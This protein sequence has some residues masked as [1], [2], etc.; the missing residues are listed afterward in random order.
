MIDCSATPLIKGSRH[1]FADLN[2]LYHPTGIFGDE[3][4]DLVYAGDVVNTTK[5]TPILLKEWFTL[6]QPSGYLTVDYRPNTFCD[7]QGLEETMWWLWKNKYEIVFHGPIAE[8][9]NDGADEKRLRGFIRGQEEIY[10]TNLNATT[11]LP[12]DAP[13]GIESGRRR[14]IC[15]KINSTRVVGDSIDKWS[16]GI[17]TSGTRKD[18]LDNIIA[19]IRRQKI[20]EYEIIVC[21]TYFDRKEADFKYIPF[22]Q[23]DEK[24]W[25]TK[26]KN[27]IGRAASFNNLCIMHDRMFLDDRWYEGMR[28]WGNSFEVLAVPQLFVET[29]ERFGDWVC[30]EGFSVKNANDF[31]PLRGGYLDYRDWHQD[32]P[33]YAAV[34]VAKKHIFASNS[35]NETLYWGNQ[36]EDLLLH[37][38]MHH[39]GYILRMN[40]DALTYSMTKSVIGF[41]W[42]HEF[43]SQEL[44]RLRKVNPLV[45][46]ACLVLGILGI[47]K[48]SRLLSPLKSFLKKRLSIQTHRSA[49]V[50]ALNTKTSDSGAAVNG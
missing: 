34:T 26:K 10:K 13:R 27:M 50:G 31:W 1:W 8:N 9:E 36:F 19:S 44:G 20:A 46:F 29:K 3:S 18:W 49:R 32:V 22:N 14:F 4:F 28:K 30:N 23:R 38:D 25:I 17:V 24:G 21:G 48:N 6:L 7:F 5:F 16:F 45:R 35:F 15:R 41:A 12:L 33:G 11:F 37:Q 2:Q 42:D 43:D 47:K 39:N 40:P